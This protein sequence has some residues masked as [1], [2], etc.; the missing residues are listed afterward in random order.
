MAFKK[1]NRF[2]VYIELWKST[3]EERKTKWGLD[4]EKVSK[5]L[6]E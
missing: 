3:E 5:L 2:G 1:Y 6:Q 4:L